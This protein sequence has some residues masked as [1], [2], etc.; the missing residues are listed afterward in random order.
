MNLINQLI[1]RK[2]DIQAKLKN[3]NVELIHINLVLNALI[4]R[5]PK[6]N[7]EKIKEY[8]KKY[9]EKK[10]EVN[11]KWNAKNRN[12]YQKRYNLK[13]KLLKK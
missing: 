4:N 3:L 1:E 8:Y 13:N 6:T 5:I 12:E 2:K 11:A 7:A 9:P 10:K